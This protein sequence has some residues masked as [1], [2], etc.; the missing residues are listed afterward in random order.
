MKAFKKEG[1]FS[2]PG[3]EKLRAKF[4]CCAEWLGTEFLLVGDDK[5]QDFRED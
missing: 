5:G 1:Q 3:V 2:M 4:S